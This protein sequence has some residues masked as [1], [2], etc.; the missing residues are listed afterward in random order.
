M[1]ARSRIIRVLAA[2]VLA[3]GALTAVSS[4]PVAAA[5]AAPT[6]CYGGAKSYD[7][8]PAY[9]FWPQ[10]GSW[11][12][13]TSSCSDINVKPGI[14]TY[15]KTCFYSTGSCNS[16]RWI[17]AGTWAVAAS[18]VLD[19]TKFFLQFDRPNAGLVAY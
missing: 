5:P 7:T 10:G 18:G 6:S 14:G 19:V 11:A 4:S 8:D 15:V 13:T 16:S 3:V 9:N 2:S 1:S 17:S 12:T